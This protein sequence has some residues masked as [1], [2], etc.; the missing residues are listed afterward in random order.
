MKI[1]INALDDEEIILEWLKG[2]FPDDIYD[3][4]LFKD[5]RL[6][7]QAFTRHTDLIITDAKVPGYDIH[8]TLSNFRQINKGVFIIIISGY[9]G[10]EF[11]LPLFPLGV[12]YVIEKNINRDWLEEVKQAV[13]EL[14]PRMVYKAQLLEV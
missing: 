14:I 6:F 1:L 8:K 9:I 5:A 2:M 3:L 13:E 7:V 4:K 11:L 10:T 12:N